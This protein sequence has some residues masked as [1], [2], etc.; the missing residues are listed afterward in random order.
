MRAYLQV[1][2]AMAVCTKIS[3]ILRKDGLPLMDSDLNADLIWASPAETILV[4]PRGP[5]QS[6]V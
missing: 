6:K 5:T 2:A 1:Q 4:H 3:K